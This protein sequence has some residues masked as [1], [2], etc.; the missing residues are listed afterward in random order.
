MAQIALRATKLTAMLCAGLVLA[1]CTAF[2][3]AAGITKVPPDEFLV[4]TKAPLILPPDYNLRPPQPGIGERNEIDPNVEARALLFPQ[5]AA[6]QVA[7][8]GDNYSDGEK[9]LLGKSRALSADPNIRHIISADAGEE[10]QGPEFTEKVLGVAAASGQPLG[11]GV[12]DPVPGP[13]PQI[14]VALTESAPALEPVLQQTDAPAPDERATLQPIAVT[15]V[16]S[17]I[18]RAEPAAPIALLRGGFDR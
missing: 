8:L 5:S 10:D 4:L 2:Q 17:T 16:A 9:F 15:L 1:G 11:G 13:V 14:K 6:T 12:L 7:M 3:H 18:P